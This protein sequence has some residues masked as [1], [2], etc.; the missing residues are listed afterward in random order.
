MYMYHPLG[1]AINDSQNVRTI[2]TRLH[3]S[4]QINV[5]MREATLQD[6]DRQRLES[7]MAV[8]L[9]LLAAEARLRPCGDVARQ[10]QTAPYESGRDKVMGGKPPGMRNVV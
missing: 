7:D 10:T 6:G 3:W 5:N 4:H 9:V 1:C 8:N 2:I